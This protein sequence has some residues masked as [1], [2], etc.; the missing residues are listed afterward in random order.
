MHNG[1]WGALSVPFNTSS[2]SKS[3]QTVNGKIVVVSTAISKEE[4]EEFINAVVD[5]I[6]LHDYVSFIIGP[7]EPSFEEDFVNNPIIQDRMELAHKSA[8]FHATQHG[9]RKTDMNRVYIFRRIK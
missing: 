7:R 9:E 1:Y 2:E 5:K 6:P 4:R 8:L 3:F